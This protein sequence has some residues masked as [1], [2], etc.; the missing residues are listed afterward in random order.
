[1][2]SASAAGDLGD[3]AG[4]TARLDEALALF[5][6]LGDRWGVA[7]V[8]RDQML[9]AQRRGDPAAVAA[10]GQE[11]L[12]LLRELGTRMGAADCY[13]RLAWAAHARGRAE[14]AARLLG[15]AAAARAAA[16]VLLAPVRRGDH[17]GAVAAARAALG[18]AAFAA[19][20][21]EGQALS[22]DEAF[23][24]ALEEAGGDG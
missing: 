14:P 24:A 2:Y 15:A 10:L 18:A 3:A 20:W 1:M 11:F 19:A 5:R 8:R 21:A 17:D 12:R 7:I 4:A 13:E 9:L 6:E 22:P 23:A 16:G